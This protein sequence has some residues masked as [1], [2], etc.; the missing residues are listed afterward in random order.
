[1]AMGCWVVYCHFYACTEYSIRILFG[2]NSRP[3][4]VFVFDRIILT[5]VDRIRF[6]I[7]L[8]CRNSTVSHDSDWSV[9]AAIYLNTHPAACLFNA[10][11]KMTMMMN[12]NC[13]DKWQ[14]NRFNV[15]SSYS[16][17]VR[18]QPNSKNPY[19]VQ[20]FA[21]LV[22]LRRCWGL[23]DCIFVVL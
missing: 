8:H 6:V 12:C 17:S 1:M 21:V 15:Q 2:L 19:S 23:R 11:E 18:I 13:D 5:I 7:Q 9:A 3:N 10:K 4:S 22:L 20:P 14:W 16:Y